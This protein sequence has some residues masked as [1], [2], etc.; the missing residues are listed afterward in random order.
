MRVT[1]IADASFCSFTG[2]GGYGWWA[3]SER[4]KQGGGGAMRDKVC[5]SSAA[6]MIAIVNGLHMAIKFGIVHAGDHVLLQTDCMA[7]LDG[8]QHR[9]TKQLNKSELAAFKKLY[10][11]KKQHR[12]TYSFRHVK[13]HSNI[14]EARYITNNL[15]DERAKVG[16]RL[17][18]RRLGGIHGETK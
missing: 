15:C 3:A 2:A 17:A 9:R 16:M 11:L 5:S 6:E 4:G 13:G 18:R 10:E 12:L 7:A 8:F 14:K 1:L